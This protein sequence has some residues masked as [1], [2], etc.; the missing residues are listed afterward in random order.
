MD[1]NSNQPQN[2]TAGLDLGDKATPT[3]ASSTNRV[4]R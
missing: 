4:A 2:Y 3:Y 1:G